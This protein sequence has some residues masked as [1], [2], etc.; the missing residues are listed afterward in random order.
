MEDEENKS[1]M[2]ETS[3]ELNIRSPVSSMD[4]LRII[5]SSD[6]RV[7]RVKE[8]ISN[9]LA[10][11]P[12][13][14]AQKLV[15]AG[16]M[17]EDGDRLAD[18]IR[19]QDEC[20]VYTLHL[21]CSVNE[22]EADRLELRHRKVA[23]DQTGADESRTSVLNSGELNSW[24]QY[25]QLSNQSQVSEYDPQQ[26]A[27]MQEMYTQYLSQYMMYMQTG[28]PVPQPDIQGVRN[29]TEPGEG[30]RGAQVV[31]NAGGG[32]Q[33]FQ[34]QDEPG[35]NRDM[36]DWLYISIRILILLSV[37]YFYSS[38]SR[39]M[40]VAIICLFL[41][42]LQ[43]GLWHGENRDRH[44]I[45]QEVNNIRDQQQQRHR[46]NNN[47]RQRGDDQGQQTEEEHED[48]ENEGEAVL[49][50]EE[51]EEHLAPTFADVMTNF[52]TSFF[53]SILPEPNQVF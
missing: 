47:N 45:Q 12:H 15:Y 20:S 22:L 11:K 38:F 8:E 35:G 31:M 17:L 37:V 50:G 26:M 21:V 24:T 28:T 9:R 42:S 19:F 49:A 10:G 29:E 5:C 14:T 43:G 48:E 53:T 51:E 44:N 46:N 23:R 39:F 4:D 41:Y 52:L 7:M 32:G 25:L 1:N 34:D 30:G 6:W 18:F 13:P 2:G 3:V 27:A 16:K 36:L 33:A 40:L